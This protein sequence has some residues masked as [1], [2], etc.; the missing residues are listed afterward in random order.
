MN[1]KKTSLL[2]KLLVPIII[3]S[4]LIFVGSISLIVYRTHN[5]AINDAKKYVNATAREYATLIGANINKYF[6][7][8]YSLSSVFQGYLTFNQAQLIDLT[9]NAL[10]RVLEDNPNVLAT[11]VSYD[12]RSIDPTWPYSYGRRRITA[13]RDGTKIIRKDELID[14]KGDNIEGLYYFSKVNKKEIISNPYFFTYTGS[15]QDSILET[16]IGAPIVLNDKFYGLTG[17]D[18]S[19]DEFNRLVDTI[20][21]FAGAQS[22]LFSNNAQIVAFR[23]EK[24]IGKYFHEL[25]KTDNEKYNVEE[26]IKKG[27]TFFYE[28]V[29]RTGNYYVTYTPILLGEEKTP[30]SLQIATPLTVIINRS[31]QNVF[32]AIGMGVVGLLFLASLIWYISQRIIS[33]IGDTIKILQIIA[34]GAISKAQMLQIDSRDELQ[35]MAESLNKLI[36]SLRQTTGF[37][38]QIGKGNLSVEYQ[39]M[40]ENDEIG[41]ALLEMQKGLQRAYEEEQKRKIEDEKQNWISKG[42][43]LFGEIL[44]KDNQSVED[45]AYAIIMNLVKYMDIQQGAIYTLVESNNQDEEPYLEM[46]AAVAF[47]RR[48]L[49]HARFYIGE[50]LVGRCAHEKSTIYMIDIP[51]NYVYINTGMAEAKPRS[52]LLVPLMLNDDVFGVIELISFYYIDDYKIKFVERISESVAGTL[53]NAKINQRTKELLEQSQRQREELAAQEEEM[54]QNLEELQATQGEAARREAEMQSLMK[55][56]SQIAVVIEFDLDMNILSINEQCFEYFNEKPDAMIGLPHRALGFLE[57]RSPVEHAAF[58]RKVKSNNVIKR[59]S[60]LVTRTKECTMFELYAP[61]LNHEG[62]ITRYVSVAIDYSKLEKA[63]AG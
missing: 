7:L 18:L 24:Y 62:Q 17:V 45:L 2:N 1:K 23:L 41:N 22:I 11:W 31:R 8:S 61:L 35:T 34:Q 20:S 46:K 36:E 56:F 49:L 29:F 19:L 9:Y 28:T 26:R 12:L 10:L 52:I 42:I 48:R 30:W 6:T 47:D 63:I 32:I 40:S 44:H 58:I 54:R 4:T 16:S 51:D 39:L 14:L 15:S 37:A 53:S 25:N 43:A 27:D 59:K 50:G 3:T 55:L 13:F 5:L 60:T 38:I 33:P 21:P 57:D